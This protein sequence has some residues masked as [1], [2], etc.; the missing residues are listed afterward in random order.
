[1]NLVR[2]LFL[3]R[4]VRTLDDA[5]R[6]PPASL[7]NVMGCASRLRTAVAAIWLFCAHDNEDVEDDDESAIRWS[8]PM[9]CERPCAD[10]WADMLQLRGSSSREMCWLCFRLTAEDSSFSP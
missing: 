8:G 1:M 6:A 7:F 10:K 3:P 5:S 9:D 4:N 2:F